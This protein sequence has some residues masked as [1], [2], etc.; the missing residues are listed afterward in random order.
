MLCAEGYVSPARGDE[1]HVGAS[2]RFDRIDAAYRAFECGTIDASAYYASLRRQLGL[3]LSEDIIKR[4]RK[5]SDREMEGIKIAGET[6]AALRSAAQGV[7]IQTLGWEHRL[8]SILDVA[9]L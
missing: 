9:G 5:A 4:I 8:G 3:N 7:R 6:V 2:F 1:H